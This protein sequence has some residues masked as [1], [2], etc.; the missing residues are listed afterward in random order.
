MARGFDSKFVEAQQ[1]EAS[2]RA[3]QGPALTA[4]QRAVEAQR[5][6]LKLARARATSDLERA[7]APAHRQML[8]QAIRA[9]DD[10][11]SDL[12]D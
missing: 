8:E 12:D 7:T 3:P 2:R 9:L 11:L 6:A 10:Q 5:Q 4:E 1:E